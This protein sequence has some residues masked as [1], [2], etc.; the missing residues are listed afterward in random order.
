MAFAGG[1]AHHLE[2]LGCDVGSDEPIRQRVAQAL[3]G[4]EVL[5]AAH[6]DRRVGR[7]R[8]IGVVFF[9]RGHLCAHDAQLLLHLGNLFVQCVDGGGLLP[10]GGFNS[11]KA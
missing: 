10:L 8:E 1:F 4:D 9:L 6:K 3:T 5:G 7:A 2:V 11:S